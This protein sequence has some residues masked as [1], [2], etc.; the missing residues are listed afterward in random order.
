M[1]KEWIQIGWPNM[2]DLFFVFCET[3]F[4]FKISPFG[5]VHHNSQIKALDISLREWFLIKLQVWV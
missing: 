3:I 2:N 4:N 5:V 1:A